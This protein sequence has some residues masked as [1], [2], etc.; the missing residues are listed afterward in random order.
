MYNPN[1]ILVC[2]M[3]RTSINNGKFTEDVTYT[4]ELTPE[5][6]GREYSRGSI[7]DV[8]EDSC[9]PAGEYRYYCQSCNKHFERFDKRPLL[10]FSNK[11]GGKL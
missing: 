7:Q 2:P 8:L 5:E 9:Q 3:C 6:D 4:V 11:K 1:F 10:S